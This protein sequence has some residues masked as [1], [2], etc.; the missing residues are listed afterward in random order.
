MNLEEKLEF[1]CLDLNIRKYD[2]TVGLHPQVWKPLSIYASQ[3]NFEL[4]SDRFKNKVTENIMFTTR[5]EHDIYHVFYKD[6]DKYE[7]GLNFSDIISFLRDN[8]PDFTLEGQNSATLFPRFSTLEERYNAMASIHKE[9]MK[10]ADN[11]TAVAGKIFFIAQFH[12]VSSF[13]PEELVELVS[14]SEIE[15]ILKFVV[16]LQKCNRIKVPVTDVK[17]CFNIAQTFTYNEWDIF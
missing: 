7:S 1:L 2:V 16:F 8:N 10:M 5:P 15:Q 13:A 17:E 14:T 9:I 3:Y 6:G 11:D 4:A 12:G